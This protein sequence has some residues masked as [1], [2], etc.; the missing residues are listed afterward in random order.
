MN[1]AEL[2]GELTTRLSTMTNAAALV[3][4]NGEQLIAK[5]ADS[6]FPAASLIKLPI[7]KV[8]LE[9]LDLNQQLVLKTDQVVGGA[10]VLQNFKEGRYTVRHLLSLMIVVSDNTAANLIIDAVGMTTINDWLSTH[11]FSATRLNR[12]LMDR[13]AL[14]Q[15]RENT[16]SANEMM[17]IFELILETAPASVLDWFLNQQMRF[18]LPGAFDELGWPIDVY[19][20]T[21]EGNGVDHDI[22]RFAVADQLVDI[23]VLTQNQVD[24]SKTLLDLQQLGLTVANALLS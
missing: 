11:G 6:I 17:T 5:N 7:L 9:K 15:G 12:K 18:K 19:N 13:I 16:T 1:E 24:R 20:K 8:A 21:G 2:K 22:A 10:G 14:S 3:D 4:L 23:I